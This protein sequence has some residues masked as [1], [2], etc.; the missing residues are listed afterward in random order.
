M[1][2][3][4]DLLVPSLQHRYSNPK[5]DRSTYYTQLRVRRLLPYHVNVG[6]QSRFSGEVWC[7]QAVWADGGSA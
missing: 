5:S 6:L 2:V 4:Q 3:I 1:I 7:L